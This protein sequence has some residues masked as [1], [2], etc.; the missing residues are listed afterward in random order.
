MYS[1]LGQDLWILEQTNFQ[2]NGFF[3]D[4]GANDGLLHSNTYLLE[5]EY[6]WR[7]VC[8][9]PSLKFND[10]THNRKNILDNLC[11]HK[12]SNK[13]IIFHE[14][15]SNLELSGISD[16]FDH[17]GHDRSQFNSRI[18]KTLSLTDLCIKH[19]CP[20]IIDYLSIDTEGS[21]LSILESHNFD[22]YKFLY[23][24][25]EHNRR[26]NYRKNINQFLSNKGYILD[27]SERFHNINNNANTNFDDWYVLKDI[28]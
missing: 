2:K 3:L 9:E 19:N 7:G 5:K 15:L 22:T 26:S 23:I 13:E 14:V 17:D 20:N 28:L 4:I 10:L 11:I 6:G 16:F 27:S 8:V 18:I 12:E 1:Q 21:E 24:T 25:I